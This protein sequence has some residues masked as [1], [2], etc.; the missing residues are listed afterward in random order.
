MSCAGAYATAEEFRQQW[1][2]DFDD[3]PDVDV[4]LDALLTKSAGRIHA[5]LQAS[6]QC[7]CTLASWATDYLKELNLV[8]AAVMFNIPAVRLSNEQRTIF[9]NYL[10]E[11][12]QLIR[13]GNLELCDGETAKQH[14]AFG[15]AQYALTDRAAATIIKN[16]ELD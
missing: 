10:G 7:D 3:D 2:Y 12:L 1:F 4:D 11:Q 9:N 15:I 8:T 5:A 14:P 6:G 16:R 13:D